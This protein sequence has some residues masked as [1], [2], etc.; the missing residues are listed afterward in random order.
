MNK[1]LAL[2]GVFAFSFSGCVSVTQELPP[3]ATYTL[4]VDSNKI[5]H[6]KNTGYALSVIEPKSM[7]SINSIL[8]SYADSSFKSE[9]YALSK[10]SDKP[11]KM[12]QYAMVNYLSSTNNFTYVHSNTLNLPSDIQL[13]SELDSFT[14]HLESEKG[15]VSFSMRVF[16]LHKG[17]LYSNTFSYKVD[18]T[19]SAKSSVEALNIAVNQYLTELNTWI[20]TKI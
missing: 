5:T 20:L 16:L 11:T 15:Y 14:Q 3:F 19:P 17:K 10:W 13:A 6:T 18:S 12:L 9:N 2:A 8:V 7:S 4:Q 1:Y